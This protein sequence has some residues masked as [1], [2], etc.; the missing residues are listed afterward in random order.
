VLAGTLTR[1]SVPLPLHLYLAPLSLANMS[2]DSSP[3]NRTSLSRNPHPGTM[4]SVSRNATPK[5]TSLNAKCCMQ[6]LSSKK[7]FNCPTHTGAGPGTVRGGPA[8][9]YD[10]AEPLLLCATRRAAFRGRFL[11]PVPWLV[12]SRDL[13]YRCLALRRRIRWLWLS[14]SRE[15]WSSAAR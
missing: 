1:S 8:A 9:E 14:C 2:D 3:L 13:D 7:N 12:E 10:A 15:E 5:S 6:F 4:S 11:I